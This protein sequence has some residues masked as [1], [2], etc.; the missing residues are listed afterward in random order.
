MNT[1]TRL[2]LVSRMMESKGA[3]PVT[4]VAETTPKLVG[5]AATLARFPGLRK[6]SRVNGFIGWNYTNSVNNQ[7][8]RE[9][10]D[11]TFVAHPRKWG[12][13]LQGTPLVSH[14]GEYY[15]ELKVERS[16]GHRYFTDT[17]E[18]SHE[19]IAPY[20][21]EKRESAR[22][23]TEKAIILRDYKVSNIVGMTIAR[24]E[25]IVI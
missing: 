25:L 1:I 24:E 16:L 19:E 2:E 17:R 21:S 20:L 8:A 7:R 14:K 6:V 10:N 15:L 4:I 22:Q 23:E 9:G 5:G 12:E 3:K 11:E 13:R 18:V